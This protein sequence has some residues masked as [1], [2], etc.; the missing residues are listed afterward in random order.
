M[1]LRKATR[2]TAAV[3]AAECARVHGMG[4]SMHSL[5]WFDHVQQH[6]DACDRKVIKQ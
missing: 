2:Y 3:V 4:S 5:T 6:D 1:A